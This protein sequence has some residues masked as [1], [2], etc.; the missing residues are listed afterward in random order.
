MQRDNIASADCTGLSSLDIAPTEIETLLSA[1]HGPGLK[2]AIRGRLP[3]R[4]TQPIALRAPLRRE[5]A[6]GYIRKR[7]CSARGP[8]LS[9]GGQA[10]ILTE[11]I[12]LSRG[13]SAPINPQLKDMSYQNDDN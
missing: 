5:G 4:R 2:D 1:I 11:I 7:D 12:R 3:T 8:A 6:H 10:T 9:E 13:Y